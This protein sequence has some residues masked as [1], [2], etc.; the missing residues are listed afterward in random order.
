MPKLW[1][2]VSMMLAVA[3]SV[4][5]AA[6]ATAQEA[7]DAKRGLAYATA[8]CAECHGILAADQTSPRR[9]VATFKKIA[10]TPGMTG[11]A[12]AV[13]L[14]TSHPTMPNFLISPEDRADIVAYILSLRDQRTEL[15]PGR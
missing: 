6:P 11:T 7:G 9:G 8:N 5:P 13:W 1:P 4:S 14:Q 2:A 12:I 10:E 3:A 15:A